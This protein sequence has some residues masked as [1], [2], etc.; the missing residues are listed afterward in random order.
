MG[1]GGGSP[2]LGWRFPFPVPLPPKVTWC[3]SETLSPTMAVSPMT[4]PVAWS[5]IMPLP[6]C[7]AGWMST[8]ITSDTRLW[9]AIASV[10]TTGQTLLYLAVSRK[11]RNSSPGK[12]RQEVIY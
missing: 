10:C 2:M 6:S 8:C 1:G 9:S 5:T 4:T 3:S 12:R 7:A 11:V